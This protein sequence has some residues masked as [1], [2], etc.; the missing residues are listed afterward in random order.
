MTR[1]FVVNKTDMTDHILSETDN[2]NNP[3]LLRSNA[4]GTKVILKC[5]CL[6]TPV[7]LWKLDYTPLTEAELLAYIAVAENGF[8]TDGTD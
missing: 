3:Y 8:I 1:Y 4:A 6:N 2:I 5:S 7:D